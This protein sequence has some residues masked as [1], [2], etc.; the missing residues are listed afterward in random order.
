MKNLFHLTII[1]NIL[2][3][4]NLNAQSCT[5]GSNFADSSFGVW[6][7]AI[8]NLPP[9]KLNEYYSTILNFK[10][11]EDAST[12]G[13]PS[14]ATIQS[15]KIDSVGGLPPGLTYVC[16]KSNCNYLG[17]DNGCANV[18][19][20]PS[21]LGS[22]PVTIYI[23]AILILNPQFPSFTLPYQQPF[24]GYTIE[25]G[26]AENIEQTISPIKVYPNPAGTVLNIDG[27]TNSNNVQIMNIEGKVLI[28]KEIQ[29]KSTLKLDI[30]SLNR[31]VYFVSST[32]SRGLEKIRFY[33][34]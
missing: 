11:P 29:D 34:E 7:S 13:G 3:F 33:K 26:H 8:E 16:N 30:S 15:F 21:K 20:T 1:L 31:G 32:H 9:G 12:V 17:G 27:I 4:K 10:A 18:Y 2:A 5:A 23:T 14:G 19:G 24:P 28:S 22:Y 25:I 6:P